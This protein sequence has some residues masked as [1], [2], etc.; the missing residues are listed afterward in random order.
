MVF[1]GVPFYLE[2]LEK[3]KSIEQNIDYLL[4]DK[5]GLLHNEHQNL[6]HALFTNAVKYIE[7][8]KILATK[9]KGLT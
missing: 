9:N 2:A 4:F 7:I 3:E 8:I 1:G 5:D 6:Y